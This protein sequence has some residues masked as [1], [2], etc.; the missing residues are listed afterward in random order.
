MPIPGDDA[1]DMS[2]V[3]SARAGRGD[4]PR[5]ARRAMDITSMPIP[6]C[7]RADMSARSV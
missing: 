7:G 4:M 3:R 1:K 6:G 5:L 2:S